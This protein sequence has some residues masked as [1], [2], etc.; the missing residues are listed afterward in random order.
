MIKNQKLNMF[1]IQTLIIGMLSCLMNFSAQASL[2]KEEEELSSRFGKMSVCKD[3]RKKALP[4]VTAPGNSTVNL[5]LWIYGAHKLSK[6][7]LEAESTCSEELKR[8]ETKTR[9]GSTTQVRS[10]VSVTPYLSAFDIDQS[11]VR[12]DHHVF[13]CAFGILP[14]QT[15]DERRFQSFH[16][17]LKLEGQNGEGEKDVYTVEATLPLQTHVKKTHALCLSI[18]PDKDHTQWQVWNTYYTRGRNPAR[19]QPTEELQEHTF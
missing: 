19:K 5:I 18:N 15:G 3:C 8:K 7:H 4:A 17:T 9:R 16:L 2:P 11:N 13:T 10:L 12:G 14:H 1:I 6:G